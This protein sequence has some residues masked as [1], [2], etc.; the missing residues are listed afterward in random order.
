MTNLSKD[1]AKSVFG[2]TF[3]KILG[4]AFNHFCSFQENKTEKSGFHKYF[5]FNR[6]LTISTV[7]TLKNFNEMCLIFRGKQELNKGLHFRVVE[8]WLSRVWL[9]FFLCATYTFTTFYYGHPT[10]P[11]LC[12]AKVFLFV[13]LHY[14]FR[15]FKVRRSEKK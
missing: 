3:I 8:P 7:C 13:G 1:L 15:N 10:V 12:Q 2:F 11:P 5:L 6:N 14:I 9:R 4:K